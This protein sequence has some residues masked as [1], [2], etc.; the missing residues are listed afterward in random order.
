MILHNR[1]NQIHN[2]IQRQNKI[3]YVIHVINQIWYLIHREVGMYVKIVDKNN[4]KY[5]MN[6]Q[7]GI[8]MM[9][10]ISNNIDK[11]IKQ[12]YFYLLHH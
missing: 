10:I 2:Q 4:N 12:I 11:Q 3:S 6:K 1:H 7:N 9:K 8:N 5:L